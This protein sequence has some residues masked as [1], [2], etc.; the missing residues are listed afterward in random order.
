MESPQ[1]PAHAPFPALVDL[2]FSELLKRR[3]A[4][5][6]LV[7]L[8]PELAQR[9]AD[10]LHN[11]GGVSAE[12]LERLRACELEHLSFAYGS[13]DWLELAVQF[14]LKSLQLY[15]CAGVTDRILRQVADGKVQTPWLRTLTKLQ[16]EACPF[17]THRGLAVVP[18]LSNLATLNMAG[19]DLTNPVLQ[20]FGTLR[21]LR[22][23]NLEGCPK[24]SAKGLEGLAPLSELRELYLSQCPRLTGLGPLS[25]LVGLET[26]ELRDLNLPD[27]A[28]RALRPLV[29]LV[30]LDLYGLRQ[31]TDDGL[32]HLVGLTK[33]RYLCVAHTKVAARFMTAL[34][35][36]G[37]QLEELHLTQAD[38]L[39]PAS[40]VATLPTLTKLRCLKLRRML[41]VSGDV[42]RSLAP[43][44]QLQK[45]TLT[46]CRDVQMTRAHVEAIN[47][48]QLRILQARGVAWSEDGLEAL[49]EMTNLEFLDI[50]RCVG[51]CAG[52]F[53]VLGRLTQLKHLDISFCELDA[54]DL[55]ALTSL[56]HLELLRLKGCSTAEMGDAMQC[57]RFLP[58]ITSLNLSQCDLTDADL[59]S[60]LPHLHRIRWLHI[61]QCSRI[62]GVGAA[63]LASLTGLMHLNAEGT[64]IGDEGLSHLAGLSLLEELD[65]SHS[66]KITNRGL[67]HLQRLERLRDLNLTSCVRISDEGV[68]LLCSLPALANLRIDGSHISNRGMRALEELA[69]ARKTNIQVKRVFGNNKGVAE[70]ASRPIRKGA[71][72][73]SIALMGSSSPS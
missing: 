67:V 53:G 63:A 66:D 73:Q 65:V 38:Q 61:K 12:E 58:T 35:T 62:T 27:K 44:R 19:S 50:S 24:I 45:V 56:R 48:R 52:D 72:A 71:R 68:S 64:H 1:A 30:H 23:L 60:F 25:R 31:V 7:G 10:L 8:P 70:S 37:S 42:V 69:S 6:P 51:P 32:M 34:R 9:L 54:D 41:W 29:N 11:H 26:L 57:L 39:R 18:L 16:I 4:L 59:L 49:G 14:P 43:L 55:L 36:M 22:V 40:M 20:R 17:V 15:R 2:V 21:Q 5:P 33:L 13:S 3:K 28:L 46:E 47:G